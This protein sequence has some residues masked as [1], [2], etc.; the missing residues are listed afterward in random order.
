MASDAEP[1]LKYSSDGYINRPTG[2]RALWAHVQSAGAIVTRS[3][4][5]AVKFLHLREV[6]AEFFATF[7]LVVRI[8]G[9]S[10]FMWMNS[11]DMHHAILPFNHISM[12]DLD[13]LGC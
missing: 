7:A 12:A 10:Q 11:I 4:A 8:Q 5:R 9:G 13:P 3:W 1:L 6:F 2:I